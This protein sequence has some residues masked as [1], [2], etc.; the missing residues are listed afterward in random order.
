[1]KKVFQTIW[2]L[3]IA[4]VAVRAL[5]MTDEEKQEIIYA[6]EAAP[7]HI[8]DSAS[9]LMFRDGKFQTIKEGN[10]KFTCLVIRNPHGRFE[11]ACL[12]KPAIES[13]LPTLEYHMERLYSGASTKQVMDEITKK[14]EMNTLPSA[15]NGALVYMMSQNNKAY[16]E[17]AKKLISFPPHQM[18]FMP[19]LPVN[20]FSLEASTFSPGSPWVYQE[21]PHMTS[22][23]VFTK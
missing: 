5:A 12:N 7:N 1:M 6:S 15:K 20:V 11:P 16:L 19:K 10:N 8:T 9:F 21:Y 17:D 2:I 22:L 4:L 13:V 23:I 18:Y 3:S 14:F